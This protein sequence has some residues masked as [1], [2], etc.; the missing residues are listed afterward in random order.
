MAGQ[1]LV[2]NSG[3]SCCGEQNFGLAISGEKISY[4]TLF[5]NMIPYMKLKTLYFSR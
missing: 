4:M 5:V 1:S 3:Q 2:P